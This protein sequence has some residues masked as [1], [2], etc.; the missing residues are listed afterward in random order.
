MAKLAVTAETPDHHGSHRHLLRTPDVRSARLA[1]VDALLVPTARRP[2]FLKD[3]AALAGQLG[4]PLVTLHSGKWTSAWE[5]VQLLPAG[6][7]LIAIDVPD[8]AGL[9]L[10]DF[11]TSRLLADTRF[12][13]RRDTSTKRNLGLLLSRMV[14]WERIVFLDDD[15]L[16][17]DPDDL[18]RAVG[19]LDTHHAV[20][21][22]IGGYPDHSVVCHAYRLAGGSQQSFIGGG[23]LA[24]GL[25]RSRSCFPDIYNE[26]W[27]Y[28]LDAERGLE[29]QPLAATGTVIQR[30]YDPFRTP[31]RARAEELGD[32]IAEGTFWLLDQGRS[33]LD[34]D[35]RHWTEFL[36][37]RARFIDHVLDLVSEGKTI[38]SGEKTRMVEALRASKGRLAH[39]TPALCRDYLHAWAA[40]RRRWQRHIDRLATRQTRE[41]ALRSLAAPG[42]SQLTWYTGKGKEPAPLG[43]RSGIEARPGRGP[44]RR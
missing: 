23:A 37:R 3:A 43:G 35:L 8:P 14:G 21:L 15:I 1:E 20:G 40:D 19:L 13:R 12:D 11:E 36:Q 5:A 17:G 24:V 29:L 33:V 26:D 42:K 38:E 10:P 31:D 6:V 28:L 30:P 18:R 44:D 7:D 4:C 16:V 9:R 39:I 34:A 41:S 27:F 2:A 25:S 32:V 22:F